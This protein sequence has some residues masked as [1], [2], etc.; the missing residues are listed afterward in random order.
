MEKICLRIPTIVSYNDYRNVL[1]YIKTN[2]HFCDF[3]R[4]NS[5]REAKE[6]RG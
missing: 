3:I 6:N 4:K 5:V 1:I 2:N